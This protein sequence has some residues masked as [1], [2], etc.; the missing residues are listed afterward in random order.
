M[1][2]V[3]LCLLRVGALGA[4]L[5]VLL[6]VLLSGLLAVLQAILLSVRPPSHC[7]WEEETA[8]DVERLLL[9]EGAT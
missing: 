1:T 3:P 5:A 7:A 9:G 4:L 6:T 8:Q 2:N